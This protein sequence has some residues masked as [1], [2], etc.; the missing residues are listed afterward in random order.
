VY[1]GHRRAAELLL[2]RGARVNATR[3][4]GTSPLYYAAKSGSTNLVELLLSRGAG[5]E[6][7][8]KAGLGPLDAAAQ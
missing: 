3:A 6:V 4:D 5:V 2:E 7:P 1:G 8:S